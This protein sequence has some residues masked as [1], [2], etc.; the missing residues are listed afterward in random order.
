MALTTASQKPDWKGEYRM[1]VLKND[2]P[3]ATFARMP[4]HRDDLQL[5]S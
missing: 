1:S 3:L 4:V 5:E 2:V